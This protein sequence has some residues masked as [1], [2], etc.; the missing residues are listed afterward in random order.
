MSYMIKRFYLMP[1]VWRTVTDS[2][3]FNWVRI[4]NDNGVNT[5]CISLSKTKESSESIRKIEEKI[6][7]KF[8]QY[9]IYSPILNDIYLFA[10]LLKHYFQCVGK[11]KLIIFQ[12]RMPNLGIPFRLIS[13]F[14]K[15]RIVFFNYYILSIIIIVRI[16]KT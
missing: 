12:T 7:G 14:P 8:Y 6:G 16:K 4:V 10:K 3:V 13:F 5:D 9:N 11:Y 15:S 1:K 2:Q